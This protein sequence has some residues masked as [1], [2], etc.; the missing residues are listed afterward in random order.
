MSNDQ[1][2]NLLFVE[3]CALLYDQPVD[4]LFIGGRLEEHGGQQQTAR[5]RALHCPLRARDYDNYRDS[6]LIAL[7]AM[8]PGALSRTPSTRR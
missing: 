1:S 8:L 2:S 4:S 3:K 5:G 7:A 6:S